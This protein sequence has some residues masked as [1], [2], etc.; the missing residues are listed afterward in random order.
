[1]QEHI[2]GKECQQI[3]TKPTPHIAK[4]GLSKP[5]EFIEEELKSPGHRQLGTSQ[6][7]PKRKIRRPSKQQ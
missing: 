3:A 6:R 2:G 4:E 1:M 5:G 7:S